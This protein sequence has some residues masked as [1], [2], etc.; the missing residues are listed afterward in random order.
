MKLK[1]T[2]ERFCEVVLGLRNS[3]RNSLLRE[4]GIKSL[5][6]LYT[7][8]EFVIRDYIE[9]DKQ[10]KFNTANDLHNYITGK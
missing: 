4:N 3:P 5:T 9:H 2:P 1:H 10:N 6:N 7:G 8:H